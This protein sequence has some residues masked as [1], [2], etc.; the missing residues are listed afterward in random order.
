MAIE[1][2]IPFNQCQFKLFKVDKNSLFCK[3]LLVEVNYKLIDC[4]IAYFLGLDITKVE[5]MAVTNIDLN[6][7]YARNRM[8]GLTLEQV[9]HLF[10]TTHNPVANKYKPILSKLI[11]TQILPLFNDTTKHDDFKKEI[12]VNIIATNQP[13]SMSSKEMAELTGVRHDNVM[14]TIK[15]LIEKKILLTS[16]CGEYQDSTGRK[17]PCYFSD[18]RDSLVIVAR[19]SP[20]F[21]AKVVDRWQELENNTPALPNFAD[22]AEA[23]IAWA[24]Q[25]KE[26]Q[27]LESKLHEAQPL[28][29]FAETAQKANKG[30]LIRD[31]AYLAQNDGIKIGE[32]RLWTWF[33]T[34]GF[35]HLRSN[36]PMQEYI[37]RGYFVMQPTFIHHNSGM[38]EHFTTKIT[39][40]GQVYFLQKLKDF[41]NLKGH[42]EQN[43]KMPV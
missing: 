1:P 38:H 21:T 34:M 19:L 10:A 16:N 7:A 12:D 40:K 36:R 11:E 39:G 18:K 43:N 25:Y 28:I 26:K 9:Q 13:L 42:H 5:A 15:S 41:F 20:E 2:S 6:Y 35:I 30:I 33:R 37:E 29:G 31:L 4:T 22:P 14:R 3:D 8:F 24:N 27:A 32:K 17:L 23:A